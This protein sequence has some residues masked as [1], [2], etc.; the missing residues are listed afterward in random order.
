MLIP[1]QCPWILEKLIEDIFLIISSEK[2]SRYCMENE[3]YDALYISE[4]E[5]NV[6]TDSHGI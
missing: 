5:S 6:L 3:T 1:F 2:C 4:D